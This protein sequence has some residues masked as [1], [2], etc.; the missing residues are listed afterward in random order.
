MQT[1]KVEYHRSKPLKSPSLPRLI[2]HRDME[3]YGR[4][5]AYNPSH[6]IEMS[7]K[8]DTLVTSPSAK[9][10]A[11]TSEQEHGW[12]S[13]PPE[14]CGEEKISCPFRVSNPNSLV[15]HSIS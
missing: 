8:P 2:K 7:L 1:K 9:K 11:V 10:P 4:T 5:E 3:T 13:E 6:Y 12:A 15:I 14:H